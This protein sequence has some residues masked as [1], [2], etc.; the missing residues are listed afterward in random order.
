MIYQKDNPPPVGG[1]NRYFQ[2]FEYMFIFSKGK[3]KTFN[4]ITSE[5]RN[6]WGDKRT[7][8]YKGF[9]RDKDGN[10]KKK[11]V[12][13]CGDVKTGNLWKYVVGGGSSV[14]NG[15]EHPAGFPEKLAKDHI[16]SWSNEGDVILDPFAGSGT[17]GKV[18]EQLGRDCI[19]I[20]KE[21]KY[22]EI[23]HRRLNGRV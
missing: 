3:P 15:T 13:L 11:Q 10:F 14:E 4:A 23:I 18:A 19:L 21:P 5:R 22:I 1:S 20:E 16:V 2:H 9:T 12:S 6:K 7:K 17:T 8:R